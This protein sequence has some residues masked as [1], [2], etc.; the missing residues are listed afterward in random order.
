MLQ[1]AAIQ[2][3]V[4]VRLEVLANRIRQQGMSVRI[5]SIFGTMS[6]L[7]S[8]VTM[9]TAKDGALFAGVNYVNRN[10]HYEVWTG[11]WGENTNTV[12]CELSQIVSPHSEALLGVTEAAC[13]FLMEHAP[14][15]F[16]AEH[17]PRF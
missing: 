2:R 11:V 5:E 8:Y 6:S 10:T 15:I 1:W 9:T 7:S 16:L 12:Y 4:W 17:A 14:Q 13:K 3:S